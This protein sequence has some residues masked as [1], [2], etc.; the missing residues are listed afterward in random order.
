VNRRYAN[1]NFNTLLSVDPN[2]DC[3]GSYFTQIARDQINTADNRIYLN[4]PAPK[5]PLIVYL[6]AA[7]M[8]VYYSLRT[9][10]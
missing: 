2:T 7:A 9:Y 1:T 5:I 6:A 4:T 3:R 10:K 8:F